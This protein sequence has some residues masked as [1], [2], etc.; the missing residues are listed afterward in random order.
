[1]QTQRC[2]KQT[3]GSLWRLAVESRDRSSSNIYGNHHHRL[4]DRQPPTAAQGA[5]RSST[6]ATTRGIKS[7][8]RYIYALQVQGFIEAGEVVDVEPEV[9]E[10]LHEDYARISSLDEDEVDVEDF[11]QNGADADDVAEWDALFTE[12]KPPEALDFIIL[13]YSESVLSNMPSVRRILSMPVDQ[14]HIAQSAWTNEEVK[15]MMR[16]LKEDGEQSVLRSG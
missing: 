9:I 1:M 4:M 12:G 6:D 13:E 7:Q 16:T 3:A 11:V 2:Q 5:A 15:H 8:S 10:D 14:T